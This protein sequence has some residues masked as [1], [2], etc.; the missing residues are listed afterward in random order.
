MTPGACPSTCEAS[1]S[2]SF[3]SSAGS[4]AMT[5]GKFII[6][7]TP[8]ARRRRR[9]DSMSPVESDAP[10]RLERAR[11]HARRRHHVDVERHVLAHVQQ[12]VHAVRAEHVGDLVRVA[13]DRRGAVGQ[14]D[15]G[16]LVD[17]QLAGLDVHVRVDE[18]RHQRPPARV[19]ALA[20]GVVAHP[21]DAHRRRWPRR[22]PATRG[23][24][25][26]RPARPRSRG[27]A[28][29]RRGPRR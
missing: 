26:R 10:R 27:R 9:I 1:R 25:R 16:E 12:P 23:C 8:S 22:R 17:H 24:A 18:A 6:S 2:A 20:A 28:P 19:D 5:A 4:P 3:A 15:A 11:G 13:D 21:R 29:R 7:A 14:H